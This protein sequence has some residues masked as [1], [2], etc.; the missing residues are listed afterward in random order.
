MSKRVFIIHGWSGRPNGKDW[1]PWLGT[2]L[3]K[4]GFRASIPKM[5][6]SD[7]PKI[8]PWI[9]HLK[10]IVGKPDKDTYFVGHSIGCQAIMRYLEQL[11]ENQKVGGVI[12]VA[13]WFN[14]PYLG[15]EKEKKVARP[16][17][18]KPVDFAKVRKI[19]KKSVAIFSDNDPDVPLS[20]NKIFK[21]KFGSKIIIEHN[22]G[23]FSED[24]GVKKLPAALEELLKMA[25]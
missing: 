8:M 23:H 25:K 22:K 4:R 2:E 16:W 12:F 9:A 19:M 5:P 14:L 3:S 11:P 24:A 15:T 20:D 17:L 10:K 6:D 21:K 7:E 18:T 13:G 1:L